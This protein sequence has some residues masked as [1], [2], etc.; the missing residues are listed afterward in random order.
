MYHGL[1]WLVDLVPLGRQRKSTVDP[2]FKNFQEVVENDD[3]QH[4]LSCFAENM[5]RI[6]QRIS[7]RSVIVKALLSLLPRGDARDA[8]LSWCQ[9]DADINGLQICLE[10]FDLCQL[11]GITVWSMQLHHF[12]IYISICYKSQNSMSLRDDESLGQP[13]SES[14]LWILL[15]QFL[16]KRVSCIHGMTQ[17]L[18]LAVE[19]ASSDPLRT[20]VFPPQFYQ[21]SFQQRVLF[22]CVVS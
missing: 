14:G 16:E 19:R 2:G 15:P 20:T 5:F 22:C 10:S 17:S 9:R 18:D 8:A 7:K 11:R 12:S 4:W 6:V 1:P 21:W 13:C 3:A